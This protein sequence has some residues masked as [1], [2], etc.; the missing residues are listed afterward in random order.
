MVMS[1]RCLSGL[2]LALALLLSVPA[3]ASPFD[4]NTDRRTATDY[5]KKPVRAPRL[6]QDACQ[7]DKKCRSWT[8]F[9]NPDG[10]GVCELGKQEVTPK[11]DPCCTSGTP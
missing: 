8:F 11:D 5:E 10:S 1:W 7:L 2:A 4:P 6:C 3:G 9:K